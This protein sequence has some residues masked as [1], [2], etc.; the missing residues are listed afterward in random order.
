MT[1]KLADPPKPGI[2]PA[3]LESQSIGPSTFTDGLPLPK[4]IVFDLDY[5]LWPFWVDTHLTPPLKAKESNSKAVDRWGE[6][7]TFYPS[8]PSILAAAVTQTSSPITLSLASRTSAPDLAISLLKMLQIPLLS[9]SSSLATSSRKSPFGSLTPSPSST[10]L[11][12]LSTLSSSTA[13]PTTSSSKQSSKRALDFFSHPQI[14]PGD[15]KAHFAKIKKA[16]GVAYEDMLFFDDEVRNRNV[17]ALGV[18]M[19]LVRDGVSTEEVDR[20]VGE[21]R[22]RRRRGN[23]GGGP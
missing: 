17:E 11:P 14:Y 1:K 23:E 10:S 8:I 19:W 4:I 22:K 2:P 6:S 5:T 9:S 3:V 12:T 15:K 18:C 7:F 20:G 21:W 16:T 13:I